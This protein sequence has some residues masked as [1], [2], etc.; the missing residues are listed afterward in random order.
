MYDFDII[1]RTGKSN[2]VANTLS[3]RPE[4]N[5]ETVKEDVVE[6]DEDKWIA[7]SYQVKDQGGCISSAEFNQAISDLVGGTKVDKKLKDRI[8]AMDIAK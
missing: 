1:Y 2:L 8:H 4:T 5:E 6:S 7:V 3:R